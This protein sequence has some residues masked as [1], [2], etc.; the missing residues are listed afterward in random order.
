[1]PVSLAA[2]L[3]AAGPSFDFA[4][5]LARALRDG[6]LAAIHSIQENRP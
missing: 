2:A 4:H 6:W 5:W 3:D 1:V